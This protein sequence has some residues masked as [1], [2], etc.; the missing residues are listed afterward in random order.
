[1]LAAA[2]AHA[3]PTTLVQSGD[4]SIAR[5]T[6]AGTCVLSAGGTV[7]TLQI[8][9]ARDFKV[10]SLAS[11]TGAS[12]IS[13]ATTDTTVTVDGSPL[14]FGRR[15]DGFVLND[16]AASQSSSYLQLDATFDLPPAGLRFVRHY[17]ITPGTP[18][19]ETW[20]TFAGAPDGKPMADLN[21]VDLQITNGPVHYL[22]GLQGDSADVAV[23]TAFTLQQ[24]SLEDGE[25]LA[26]G[27]R[28]RA[29]EQTVPWLAID[30][31]QEEFY[32]ALMWSG[33]WS[34]T[35]ARNGAAIDLSVGLAPMATASSSRTFEG[36]HVVLGLAPG[37][38][39]EATKA[40]RSYILQGIRG[41]RPLPAL[42]TYN[43][44]FAYG[45]RI[46]EASM[47]G[48]ML[49]A[50]AIGTELFVVDAGWYQGAG[51]GGFF[52]FDTGLGKW[53][54]DPGRFPG[55]FRPLTD[56]AHSLGMKFGIWVEPERVDLSIVGREGPDESWL[57]TSQ[58]GYGSD[59][60]AQIC[61]ASD[62]ARA[63]VLDRL[64]TLIDAAQP[65]YLKWDNNMWVNCDRSGHGHGPADGNFAHVSALYT[66]LQTLRD[67]YPDLLIEN[68]SGGG[69]R[70][71]VGMLRYS[72][73]AWM[74]DRTAPA[75]NVRHNLQGLS[76]VFPPAYLLSFVMSAE[77]EP[78]HGA[79]DLAAL[80]R[81]RMAGALGLC[82]KSADLGGGDL[83]QIAKQI[84]V[85]KAFRD[86]LGGAAGAL[87]TGQ[88]DAG[89]PPP[90]DVL[91]EAAP[92]GGLLVH[93]FQTNPGVATITVK[94]T[95]L[96]PDATYQV[97][98]VDNGLLGTATGADLME[99]GIDLVESRRSAAHILILSVVAQ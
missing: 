1:V 26:L 36:P 49:R 18:S 51:I 83:D 93:A 60:A 75:V 92:A 16:V 54:P 24:R 88:A 76:A 85:Y 14:A 48:E 25:V 22:N 5:D 87:L 73:V 63:W 4:A 37:G 50:A 13:T 74:D 43:T 82:F 66:I 71:D 12:W 23:G 41:G 59:H 79:P 40:L 17:R 64:T 91:Q 65:D 31:A 6:Q 86:T 10:L 95:G 58:G 3:E 30:G 78:L 96:Q 44:W 20:T 42:V 28:G 8:D 61:L 2:T 38:F 21:A 55:G 45:T 77:T 9:T 19:F 27:A 15:A 81:S 47:R 29:S 7:L 72:D 53:T 84:G 89:S 35:A 70:L 32:A 80:V 98:S 94:P 62:A 67:R 34:L 97:V 11:G 33:A 99:R 68:V 46:D 52:D 39:A 57:A 90:W 56:Y 69:N